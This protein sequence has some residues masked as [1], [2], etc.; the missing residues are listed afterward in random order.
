MDE[1]SPKRSAKKKKKDRLKL[2]LKEKSRDDKARKHTPNSEFGDVLKKYFTSLHAC[3]SNMSQLERSSYDSMLKNQNWSNVSKEPTSQRLIQS[4]SKNSKLKRDE[5]AIQLRQ[6]E[7]EF[8][9]NLPKLNEPP[10]NQTRWEFLLKRNGTYS[11]LNT[12][13]ATY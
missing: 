9:K 12:Y 6:I 2:K 5:C 1:E 3:S 13:E 11:T 4:S 8:G 7:E 10:R